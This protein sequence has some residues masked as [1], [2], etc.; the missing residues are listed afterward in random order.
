MFHSLFVLPSLSVCVSPSLPLLAPLCSLSSA[1]LRVFLCLCCSL[2]PPACRP[3]SGISP[4]ARRCAQQRV[5]EPSWPPTSK[6]KK[7]PRV[8]EGP[9]PC[10]IKKSADVPGAKGQIHIKLPNI[11]TARVHRWGTGHK[12][13]PARAW[14]TSV[15]PIS[16]AAANGWKFLAVGVQ[17]IHC[18]KGHALP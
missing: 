15:P 12:K 8:R 4:F 14:R 13:C 16:L 9:Y 7:S 18:P 17:T 11:S 6:S 5:E 1:S 2:H 3:L 10:Q